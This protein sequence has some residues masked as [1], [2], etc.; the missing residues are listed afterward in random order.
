MLEM[1]EAMVRLKRCIGDT[2]LSDISAEQKPA[3]D[4][5]YAAIRHARRWLPLDCDP[6]EEE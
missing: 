3:L 4:E 1:H 5:H 6:L 2:S